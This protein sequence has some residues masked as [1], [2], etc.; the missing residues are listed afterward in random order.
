MLISLVDWLMEF[1]PGFLVLRYLTF[2][3]AISM[4]TAMLLTIFLTPLLIRWL[5]KMQMG[6]SIHA[7]TPKSH[8]LK[9]GTPTMGGVLIVF[10]ICVSILLWADLSVRYVWLVLF[11]LV[12]FGLIG[13]FDDY[14]KIKSTRGVSVLGKFSAQIVVALGAVSYLYL[15]STDAHE[16][17]MI[18]PFFKT[19]SWEMGWLFIPFAC[20]VIVGSSNAVNLTDGLDGLAIMPSAIIA[21]ALGV[22]AYVTGHVFFA[23]YLAIPYLPDAGELV[24]VCGALVGSGLGFL[25]FN[26]HP[27]QVFMGDVGSLSIGALLGLIAVLVRHEFLFGLMAGVFV[28]EAVSVMLQVVSFKMTGKRLFKM[29]PI[30]HHFELMGWPES[31]ITVRFWIITLILTL[32]ALATLKV[33]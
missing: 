5:A 32:I 26:T 6:E 28:M 31:R 24:I 4:L 18:M 20:L 10:S 2:R 27:A 14:Q 15:S 22:I 23:E 21:G 17:A 33:R 1:D 19:F 13:L 25:W 3:G 30:H 16:L 11:V 9:H 12:G 7:L 8:Q 29:A